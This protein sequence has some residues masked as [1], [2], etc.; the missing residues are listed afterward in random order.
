M[1]R[2]KVVE[3]IKTHILRSKTIFSPKIVP[4]GDIVEKYCSVGQATGDD[5]I[6]RMRIACWIP[7]AANT[8]TG[9][10]I[11]I[12]FPLEFWLH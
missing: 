12:A 10:V 3:K 5:I 6:R 1:F 2:T 11:H 8:H 9:C 7:K 4:L